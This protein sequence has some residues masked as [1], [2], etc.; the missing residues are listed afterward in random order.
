MI[1]P[2]SGEIP[3]AQ[4]LVEGLK[5]SPADIA[6]IVPSIVQELSQS[7]ELLDYC[8]K[9]LEM[10]MFCGG[11]LTQSI[12]DVVSSKIR[13]V[14]Q[15][16]A[17]EL[18][19]I[20]LIQSKSHRD[21]GDWKY[22]EFHPDTGAQ[23]RHVTDDV[24]ELCIARH[25]KLEQQ[26]PSFT[27]FPELQEYPTRDL[28]VR[29]PAKDKSNMWRWVARADDVI[30]FIN[31]EKT[32]PISMEQ[33]I[34]SRNPG[35]AAVLVVGA[36]R[37]QAA[38]LIELVTNEKE[39]SPSERAAFIEKIWP[40]IEEAN[41]ECPAHA[42][43]AKTHILFTDPK[44]PMLRAGK[45]T[46]QRAGTLQLYAQKLDSLYADADVMSYEIN[47]DLP[48]RPAMDIDTASRIIKEKVLSVTH[49]ETLDDTDNL[50][51]RGMDSFQALLTV[52]N[53]K[54]GLFMPN[55]ALS[56]IYTNPSVSTLAGAILLLSK[57]DEV[58]QSSQ[59]QAQY[60]ERSGLIKEYQGLIDRLPMPS[61]AAKNIQDQ[62]VILTGSSGALGSYILNALLNNL[63]VSHVFCL[64]RAVDGFSLQTER[65][66]AR[67]LSTNLS[68]NRVT[69]LTADFS[70]THLGLES[71]T[72]NRMLDV[73]TLVIHNAWPVNFNL[74]LSSFR[75][76]LTGLVNFIEFTSLAATSPHMLFISSIS[77]V[78]S[79]RNDSL[80]TLE[81]VIF[82]NHAPGPNGYSESKYVS[83]RLLDHAARRLSI[84]VSFARVGQLAGAVEYPGLWN[85][86]EWFPSLV[87]SSVHVGAVPD[88]LGP[89]L[90]RI[91][92]VPIDLLAEIVVELALSEDLEPKRTDSQ[93][94]LT[95]TESP[96]KQACVFHPLNRHPTTWQAI[97]PTL[98]AAL[99]SLAGKHLSTVPPDIWLGKIRQEIE[100]TAATGHKLHDGDLDAFLRVNPAVKLL[101]FYE[102]M[103]RAGT[104]PGNVLAIG[105]TERRS[106]RLRALEGIKAEWVGKWVGEWMEQG[107]VS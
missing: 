2:T 79:Y 95:D 72:Y 11:D 91:D 4:G 94:S 69:F 49:W 13:L 90:D 39:L 66:K 70:Q 28:F 60:Q 101:D 38:L 81:E 19:L 83:E 56:T 17:S 92:W 15:Y 75:P 22:V 10:I 44:N 52:R 53:L 54:Q 6:F 67:G 32:N 93:E 97:K 21:P 29:H 76:Q 86:A 41:Q 7:P 77:S 87:I 105:E 80:Q 5:K 8:A 96:R 63:A 24:Y 48:D 31:G 47:G 65:N 35:V 59:K 46:I 36:Q 107:G 23:F 25:P 27:F 62:T 71:E 45:G 40:T 103:L 16:G 43:I 84:N 99:S 14:N 34:V 73:V 37:F 3:S 30:V 18:G 33:H 50:F 85:K 64:N 68:S 51:T 98:T 42:R 61:Q 106:A 1:A 102:E 55:I 9:N 57:Q 74:S 58:S 82:D 12:G 78:L 100:S 104:G 89:I 88:T 20:A 26:Q